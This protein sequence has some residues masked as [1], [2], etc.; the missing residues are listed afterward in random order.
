MLFRFDSSELTPDARRTSGEIAHVIS[1]VP[2]RTIAVEGHTDSLG[3]SEYNQ[4]LSEARA[5]SVARALVANGV[6]RNALAVTGKGEGDP[7]ASNNSE[8]GRQRNRRVEVIVE[9]N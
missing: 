3:T 4:R 9:N 5:H 7:I 6:S 2:G 8:S 1:K